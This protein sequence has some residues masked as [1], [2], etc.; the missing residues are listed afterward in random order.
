[1]VRRI[2]LRA[3]FQ[4]MFLTLSAAVAT[5]VPVHARTMDC[6]AEADACSAKCGDVISYQ[7]VN[8]VCVAYQPYPNQWQCQP[9]G[10]RGVY[11]FSWGSGVESFEC[12][13][14]AETRY[15]QCVY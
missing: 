12:A 3:A 13:E 14:V 9:T 5:A 4:M 15:C 6:E 2:L 8:T 11:T 7:L 10:W 1:M